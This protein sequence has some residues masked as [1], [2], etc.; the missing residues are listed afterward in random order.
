MNKK[1]MRNLTL[2]HETIRRLDAAR[3]DEVRGAAGQ[4]YTVI[5]RD[6]NVCP[7]NLDTCPIT[8]QPSRILGSCNCGSGNHR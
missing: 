1:N 8:A 3:L 5:S 6:P 2:N 4:T 7:T